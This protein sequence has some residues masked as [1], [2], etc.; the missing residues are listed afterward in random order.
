M[1]KINKIIK[2][3]FTDKLNFKC[4]Y[5]TYAPYASY[6][7]KITLNHKNIYDLDK[8]NYCL[9]SIFIGKY[10]ITWYRNGKIHKDS[11]FWLIK[12]AKFCIYLKLNSFYKDGKL[13]YPEI[14]GK[15]GLFDK[16][17]F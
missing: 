17:N 8:I 11:P 9:Y 6:G 12:P 15:I 2:E 5:L 1:K 13:I 16:N 7:Y 3:R 10:E 4:R 14:N